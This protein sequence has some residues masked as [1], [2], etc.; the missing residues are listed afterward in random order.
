MHT[1]AQHVASSAW[2]YCS[3]YIAGAINRP[4]VTIW[5]FSK[6]QSWLSFESCVISWTKLIGGKMKN[7]FYE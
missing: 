3:Y 6:I 1:Y 5:L 4:G 2:M 7:V